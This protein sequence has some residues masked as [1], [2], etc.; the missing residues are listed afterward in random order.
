[1]VGIARH[2]AFQQVQRMG[3]ALG[4]ERKHL[5]HRPQRQVMRTEIGIRLAAGAIDFR[6]AQAWLHRRDDPGGEMFVED[7]V[8]A[9]R[10]I[11]AMRR[12]MAAGF[13]VDQTESQAGL[14][15]RSADRADQ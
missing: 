8:I 2:R 3:V 6:K 7:G 14:P 10:A 9:K 1:M 13:G 4:I 12:Q 11:G 15:A 5:R